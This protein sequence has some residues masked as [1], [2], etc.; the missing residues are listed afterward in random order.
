M[1]LSTLDLQPW[2]CATLLSQALLTFYV[3]TP[4]MQEAMLQSRQSL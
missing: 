1:W 3:H 2:V 4:N